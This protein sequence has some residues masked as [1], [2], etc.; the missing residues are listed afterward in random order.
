MKI[1]QGKEVE[2][3]SGRILEFNKLSKNV[4]E[5]FQE[6]K[7]KYAVNAEALLDNKYSMELIRARIS[8]INSV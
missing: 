4:K 2:L 8:K 7:K 5:E 3:P 6:V 1:T